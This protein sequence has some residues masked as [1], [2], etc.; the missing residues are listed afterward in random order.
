M[1]S[2]VQQS[3][4][5]HL[6]MFSQQS[7][8]VPGPLPVN[9]RAPG[10]PRPPVFPTGSMHNQPGRHQIN[11]RQQGGQNVVMTRGKHGWRPPPLNFVPMGAPMMPNQNSPMNL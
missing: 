4:L 11:Q 10:R 9:M 6:Q 1:M 8:P 2:A 7:F 3:N 5:A